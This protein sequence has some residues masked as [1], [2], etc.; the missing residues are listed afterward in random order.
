MCKKEIPHN[1]DKAQCPYCHTYFH[2]S[3]LQKWIVRFGNC[4][5]CD[6]ELKKF[7]I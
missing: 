2:K 1:Q 4:P 6:R 3:K 5:R 7:V